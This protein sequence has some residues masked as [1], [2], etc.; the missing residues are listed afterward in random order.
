MRLREALDVGCHI[1]EFELRPVSARPLFKRRRYEQILTSGT[2]DG[3]SELCLIQRL[4][5]YDYQQLRDHH[6]DEALLTLSIR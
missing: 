4:N 5:D 1:D 2:N 3:Y 6:G